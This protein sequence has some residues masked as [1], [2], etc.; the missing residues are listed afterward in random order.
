[1]MLRSLTLALL[2]SMVMPMVMA[3][4]Q[5]APIE[6]EA[7]EHWNE[8]EDRNDIVECVLTLLL[9]DKPSETAWELRGP[10]P[11]VS[12]V[13]NAGYNFYEGM[14][15][16]QMEDSFF[17]LMGETYYF[18]LSDAGNDGIEDGYLHLST[19][20]GSGEITLVEDR[21]DF[22]GAKMYMFTV[23]FPPLSTHGHEGEEEPP[24]DA[25]TV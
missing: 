19:N 12:V 9:D 16:N 1:M 5:D 20:F 25:T 8:D 23:P 4:T 18:L 3:E 21:T 7:S 24:V 11:G 10:L 6:N 13:A 15:K 22:G 2:A 17:L 14:E